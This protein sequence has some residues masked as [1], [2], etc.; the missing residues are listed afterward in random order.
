MKFQYLALFLL[1]LVSCKSQI[2]QGTLEVSQDLNIQSETVEVGT[3]STRMTIKGKKKLEI[4][5]DDGTDKTTVEVR[6]KDDIKTYIKNDMILIPANR[7]DID[8]DIAGEYRASSVVGQKK[9]DYEACSYDEPVTICYPNGR[10]GGVTCRTEYQRRSG[11][12]DVEYQLKTTTTDMK[13]ALSAPNDPN[14]YYADFT[15]V[16]VKKERLYS[17]EGFCR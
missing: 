14:N 13:V 9:R 12:R 16:N 2:F 6:T 5:V 15:G 17:Y 10:R 3:Y 7:S 11:F 1:F 4:Q 8:Y